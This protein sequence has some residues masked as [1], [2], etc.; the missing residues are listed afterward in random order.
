MKAYAYSGTFTYRSF[1]P[2]GTKIGGREAGSAAAELASFI[3]NDPRLQGQSLSL[4]PARDSVRYPTLTRLCVHVCHNEARGTKVSVMWDPLI[5]RIDDASAI[6][7]FSG[8]KLIRALKFQNTQTVEP[9]Q[10]GSFSSSIRYGRSSS[11]S[12]RSK[13]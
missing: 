12:P 5:E 10:Y 7:V 8:F 1:D 13:H 4:Y 6:A 2:N 11:H 9:S 3:Q